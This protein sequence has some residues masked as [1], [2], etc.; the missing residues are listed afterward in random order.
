M[1][2][3]GSVKE[4]LDTEKR[5]SITLE[6]AKK[7]ANLK[8]KVFLE[9][10]YAKHLGIKDEEYEKVGVTFLSSQKEVL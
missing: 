6:T 2:S 9:K 7:F 3:V 4:N 1:Q 10:N 5:I 8:F